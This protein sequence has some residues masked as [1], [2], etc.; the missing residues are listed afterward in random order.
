MFGC[1]AISMLQYYHFKNFVHNNVNPRHFMIG[2]GEKY[3]KLFLVDYSNSIRYRDAQT[4]EHIAENV[5]K[6]I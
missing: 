1:E 3:G 2:A 5:D 4:L 6:K